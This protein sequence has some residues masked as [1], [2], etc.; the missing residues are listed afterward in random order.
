MSEKTTIPFLVQVNIDD[1]RLED[2]LIGAFEGGSNYWLARATPTNGE[3]FSYTKVVKGE[4]TLKMTLVNPEDIET[5]LPLINREQLIKGMQLMAE[6]APR[7]FAN[8][9]DENDDAETADV[10][11]QFALLGEIVYG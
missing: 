10:F 2:M 7:H 11:F 1:Q 4:Q 3:R 8:F 5:E 6:K 9:M